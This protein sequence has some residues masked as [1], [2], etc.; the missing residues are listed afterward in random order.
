VLIAGKQAKALGNSFLLFF[1]V[2]VI[3]FSQCFAFQ[4]HPMKGQLFSVALFTLFRI[5][6]TWRTHGFSRNHFNLLSKS[7]GRH[8]AALLTGIA[9][10]TTMSPEPS[11][12]SLSY[13]FDSDAYKNVIWNAPSDDFWYPPFMIGKWKTT[14][15]F[16]QAIFSKNLQNDQFKIGDLPGLTKYS[17]AFLPDIGVDVNDAVLHYIQLD[18]HPREDHAGNLR[19]L[20]TTLLPETVIDSAPYYYQKAPDWFHSR[21]NAWSIKYHDKEGEGMISL[22]T[23]RRDIQS[24][25]G[26]VETLEVFHQVFEVS[27]LIVWMLIRYVFL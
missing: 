24:F 10:T 18:S 19:S 8:F 25:A 27:I 13:S 2:A 21:A 12:A 15:K 14:L 4:T 22:T 20:T 26:S 3:R 9:L 23:R 11:L 7:F 6:F 1:F 17:I 16:K 5:R